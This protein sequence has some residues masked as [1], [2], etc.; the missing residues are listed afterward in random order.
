ML[1]LFNRWTKRVDSLDEFVELVDEVGYEEVEIVFSEIEKFLSED[2]KGFTHIFYNCKMVVK[3][4]SFWNKIIFEKSIHK[5]AGGQKIVNVDLARTRAAEKV[6]LNVEPV[7]GKITEKTQC[8]DPEV[9]Y[10]Q[11]INELFD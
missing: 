1:D 7:K 9:T 8:D 10:E 3:A 4:G 6:Q 2:G 11:G 5:Y